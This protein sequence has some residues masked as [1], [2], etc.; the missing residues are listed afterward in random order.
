MK[1]ESKSK[2]NVETKRVVEFSFIPDPSIMRKI[3]DSG[4]KIQDIMG[5][6]VD[7]PLDAALLEQLT[8]K[9]PLIIRI[10]ISV[11]KNTFSIID[12]ASGM[13]Q[14]EMQNSLRL[15]SSYK[16]DKEL[17]SFGVGMKAA[18]AA[19]C[20][21]FTVKSGVRGSD[22]MYEYTFD[23]NEFSKRK[24]SKDLW[25]LPLL[26][27]K[28]DVEYHGTTI[29]VDN[30]DRIKLDGNKIEAI[31]RDLG[32]RYR[33]FIERKLVKI[34]VNSVQVKIEP[35]DWEKGYPL[36]F[37]EITPYG[38]V[39]G[40]IGLMKVSNQK[41]LYGFD[42]FRNKR[43]IETN[44]KFVIGQHPTSA[45]IMGEIHLDFVKVSHT[46]NSFKTDSTEYETAERMCAK[47]VV[48]KK[49][50]SEAKKKKGYEE[51]QKE[52]RE[53]KHFIN[54]YIPFMNLSLKENDFDN[55]PITADDK[56]KIVVRN[57]KGSIKEIEILVESGRK[58]KKEELQ[59]KRNKKHIPVNND[60]PDAYKI[61][62]VQGNKFKWQEIFV[63]DPQMNRRK[64][65]FD[66]KKNKLLIYINT[67]FCEYKQRKDKGHYV[68]DLIRDAIIE[69]KFKGDSLNVLNE[70]ND[71]K[72]TVTTTSFKYFDIYRN[73]LMKKEKKSSPLPTPVVVV[74]DDNEIV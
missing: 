15:A 25:N 38:K 37:E 2:K 57:K 29:T 10:R 68:T 48:F 12:N 17:G 21:K 28:K 20:T 16:T 62:E 65:V 26:I 72:D 58:R 13:T 39:Y 52:V 49:V 55:L 18:L 23:D 27:T 11:S 22:E 70:F 67:E 43:M 36:N 33:S 6:L 32:K 7:N 44:S 19:M 51:N 5:D 46:K 61:I 73:E 9:N 64:N 31:K 1:K 24:D 30:V 50:I 34:F 69:F 47:N 53:I 66:E 14:E 45:R 3:G 8:G 4:H 71:Y 41:G 54:E 63:A 59:R 40:K 60:N 35:I 56:Q 42:V 74:E